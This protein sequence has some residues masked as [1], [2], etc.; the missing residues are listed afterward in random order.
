MLNSRTLNLALILIGG[1]VAVYAESR[2]KTKY[3]YSSWRNY[4][5]N[6]WL[7]QIV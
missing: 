6:D 4:V 7:V 5:I 1:I 2:R 3:L